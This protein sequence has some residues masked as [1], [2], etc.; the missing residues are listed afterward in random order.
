MR[1]LSREALYDLVWSKPISL[2]AGEF[3][4]S[5]NGLKKICGKLGVPVPHRGYWAKLA[6]GKPALRVPLPLREP[7]AP[8]ALKT[9][10]SVAWRWPTDPDAELAEPE[11]I[12]PI[13]DE[14]LASLEERIRRRVRKVRP[15]RDLDHPHPEIRKVL[16][17]DQKRIKQREGTCRAAAGA[18]GRPK[19][20]K[21]APPPGTAGYPPP[22]S[23]AARDR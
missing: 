8:S 22:S 7:G 18:A 4:L 16:E 9:G 13:F 2:L 15:V 20:A 11:P 19:P 3:N 14:P 17:W 1:D 12:E 6:A 10:R 5:G 21:P 23:Q